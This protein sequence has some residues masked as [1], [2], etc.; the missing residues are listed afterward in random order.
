MNYSCGYWKN[1]GNLAEAQRDKMELVGRK[2]KLEK[3][4]RVLDIGCGWGGLCKYLAETYQVSVVGVTV[5]EEGAKIAR[6]RCSDLPVEIRVQDYRS[7]TNEKFDRVVS[8]GM[9]EHVGKRN[10]RTFMEVVDRCLVNDGIF[11]L[12]TIGRGHDNAS[13]ADPFITKYIF[14]NGMIPFDSE[15]PMA[16]RDIFSIEDWHN[17]GVH[18][19]KTLMAWYEN[20][21]SNWD[22][23]KDLFEEPEKFRRM[24][25]YYLL[26]AAGLFRARKLHCWQIVLTK[27]LPGGYDSVR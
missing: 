7:V 21:V 18:Y 11:L 1:A 12:H 2:L 22:I 20:F 9:F 3:G 24:W 10:Y 13:R 4:M 6:E 26:G 14:P 23:I 16:I 15:I 19:D 25:V 17:I 27:G 5:A 8:I